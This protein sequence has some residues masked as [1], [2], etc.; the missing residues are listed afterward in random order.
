MHLIFS[1]AVKTKLQKKFNSFEYVTVV[2]YKKVRAKL[3]LSLKENYFSLLILARIF[4]S[5][6]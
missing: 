3:K 6:F 4:D 2:V 1:L 5:S